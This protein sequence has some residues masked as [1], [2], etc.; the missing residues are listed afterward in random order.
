MGLHY[1]G[2]QVWPGYRLL[3]W[4]LEL[5]GMGLRCCLNDNHLRK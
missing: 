3:R 5:A 1:T 4:L 2:A